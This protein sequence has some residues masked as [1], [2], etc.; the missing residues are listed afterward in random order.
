MSKKYKP[1]HEAEQWYRP[2]PAALAKTSI[3]PDSFAKTV[4]SPYKKIIP[5]ISYIPLPTFPLVTAYNQC[6]VTNIGL[7][8][9]FPKEPEIVGAIKVHGMDHKIV[10]FYYLFLHKIHA[11]GE[12]RQPKEEV[13]TTENSICNIPFI[14][15]I[16]IG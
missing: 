3:Y 2:A 13:E 9:P 7:P 11:H 15:L 5:T 16:F 10:A 8:N 12:Q 6:S 14:S 4:T 1:H